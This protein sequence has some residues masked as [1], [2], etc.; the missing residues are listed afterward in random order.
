MF[1]HHHSFRNQN[2]KSSLTGLDF[3][4]KDFTDGFV[5][6]QDK[7]RSS[8]SGFGHPR[9]STPLSAL[10]SRRSTPSN[11][12]SS[13]SPQI[14][15][16]LPNISA[17]IDFL[18]NETL[19]QSPSHSA[20][21]SNLISN[22]PQFQSNQSNSNSNI[23]QVHHHH[24][25]NSISPKS[26]DLTHQKN[27]KNSHFPISSTPLDHQIPLENLIDQSSQLSSPLNHRHPPQVSQPTLQ[28]LDFTNR[29]NSN[30]PLLRSH[31][32]ESINPLPTHP[33]FSQR[34]SFA[35]D[36][37]LKS[38]S[39]SSNA[40]DRM[41]AAVMEG[42]PQSHWTFRTDRNSISN[43]LGIK[44]SKVV[45]ELLQPLQPSL[46]CPTQPI[47]QVTNIFQSLEN[48]DLPQSLIDQ[49]RRT[50]LAIQNS[51]PTSLEPSTAT[52]KSNQTF[53]LPNLVRPLPQR[54]PLPSPSLNQ[55]PN[56]TIH[57]DATE[58][59]E[60][61]DARV[62]QLL[63]HIRADQLEKAN[64]VTALA[65]ARS[66]VAA[67]RDEVRL[68]RIGVQKLGE[69][70]PNQHSADA[71]L[72]QASRVLKEDFS[73][74]RYRSFS[75]LQNDQQSTSEKKSRR[76]SAVAADFGIEKARPTAIPPVENSDLPLLHGK[77]PTY[78]K[79]NNELTPVPQ[80]NED[81]LHIPSNLSSVLSEPIAELARHM[82]ADFALAMTF[83][84]WVDSL[85]MKPS[86]TGKHSN[87]KQFRS[88]DEIFNSENLENLRSRLKIWKQLIKK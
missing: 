49:T 72:E 59:V 34:Q 13:D 67:L 69:N 62:N 74:T 54:L 29:L 83:T 77:S 6:V 47:D 86:S 37:P 24:H 51:S 53:S 56:R 63:L 85:I 26:N 5:D 30:R 84:R 41:A 12:L 14:K 21:S 15:R 2:D 64:L 16:T 32:L 11:G 36:P 48:S 42:A 79:T 19:I 4:D 58:Q 78:S 8:I 17:L 22:H 18:D 40:A 45:E 52:V 27:L 80:A 66:E 76:L 46:S 33:S 44:R 70:R 88:D 75:Q 1:T 81:K 50:G 61:L 7:T 3:G 23:H 71:R 55:D 68:L 39:K 60:A 43:K 25:L 20:K 9:G 65:D 73:P 87:T 57:T 38:T 35:S 28:S 82:L 31:P 10:S